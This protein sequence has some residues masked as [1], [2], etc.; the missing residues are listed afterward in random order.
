MAWDV[1]FL[2]SNI[3]LGK[4]MVAESQVKFIYIFRAI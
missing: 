2:P 4:S 3:F 1:D